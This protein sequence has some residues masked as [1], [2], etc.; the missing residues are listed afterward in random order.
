MKV[1]FEKFL[2][3]TATD[4]EWDALVTR[5]YYSEQLKY[6][7]VR[8]DVR[9]K[10]YYLIRR[11]LIS[12]YAEKMLVE[13]N[14]TLEHNDPAW[15]IFD[16]LGEEKLEYNSHKMPDLKGKSGHLYDVKA[17]NNL[18]DSNWYTPDEN[19][20]YILYDYNKNKIK[21]LT[22]DYL[23]FEDFAPFSAINLK[24]FDNELN[25]V[26]YNTYDRLNITFKTYSF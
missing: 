7:F 24:K 2:T 1:N 5:C 12:Y 20:W 6:D 3:F 13:T 17:V 8:R 15:N 23:T 4:E 22:T 26:V 21:V 18:G 25:K 16:G 10:V 14:P 19:C 9:D 11:W